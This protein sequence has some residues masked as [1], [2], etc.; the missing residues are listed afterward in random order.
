M[1][2]AAPVG[3]PESAAAL[4]AEADEVVCLAAPEDFR[5]VGQWYADFGQ[6]T[7]EEVVSLLGSARAV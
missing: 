5:A 3:V 6:T 1:V 2:F 4:R 7:D